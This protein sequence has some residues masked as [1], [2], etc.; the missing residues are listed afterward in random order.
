MIE[1]L[2]SGS[3]QARCRIAGF[4]VFPCML[5]VPVARGP[6]HPPCGAAAAQRTAPCSD[7]HSGAPFSLRFAVSMSPL[8][9]V[10]CCCED[11]RSR[12]GKV[13]RCSARRAEFWRQ[14]VEAEVREGIAFVLA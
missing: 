2:Y 1:A 14:S 10:R 11:P 4:I 7:L 6:P 9:I 8:K 3:R 12:V 13:P 5:H